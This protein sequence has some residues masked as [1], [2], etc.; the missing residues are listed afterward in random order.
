MRDFEQLFAIT[1]S[2]THKKKAAEMKFLRR[3]PPPLQYVLE[4]TT[5]ELF[6]KKICCEERTSKKA[7]WKMWKQFNTRVWVFD[8]ESLFTFFFHVHWICEYSRV[9]FE[10][11][12]SCWLLI[13][14]IVMRSSELSTWFYHFCDALTLRPP[15]NRPT[16]R[17]FY[18]ENDLFSHSTDF[19]HVELAGCL[20]EFA[21]QLV[22]DHAIIH[23]EERPK[24]WEMEKLYWKDS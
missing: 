9:E 23:R 1:N 17:P 22:T 20:I 10:S 13:K 12:R 2:S 6:I 15:T 19:W 7:S 14:F 18:L 5:L 24:K 16:Y 3:P 21:P 8:F 11:R 4:P